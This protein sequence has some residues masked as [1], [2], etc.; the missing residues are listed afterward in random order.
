[1][2]LVLKLY[3]NQ[4]AVSVKPFQAINVRFTGGTSMDIPEPLKITTTIDQANHDT[5][6]QF[7]V[8]ILT[9]NPSY[10]C[11]NILEWNSLSSRPQPYVVV[12]SLIPRL[13]YSSK[14]TSQSSS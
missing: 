9:Q 2:I 5:V 8:V 1:M 6:E 11:L 10:N 3:S 12:D 13:S 14:R 7:I 4:R